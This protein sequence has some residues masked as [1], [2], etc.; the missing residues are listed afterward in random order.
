MTR[1]RNVA[2]MAETA[3]EANENED[4]FMNTELGGKIQSMIQIGITL[5]QFVFGALSLLE[6]SS[7]I[8]DTGASNHMCCDSKHLKTLKPIK[9]IILAYL[10]NGTIKLVYHVGDL[11]LNSTVKL[12]YTLHISIF[13]YNLISVNKLSE[14]ALIRFLFYPSFCLLQD[15]QTMGKVVS[16]LYILDSTFFKPGLLSHYT[17][18]IKYQ[19]TPTKSLPFDSHFDSSPV[20]ALIYSLLSFFHY[21]DVAPELLSLLPG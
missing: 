7:W 15:L 19:H 21:Y 14:I 10:P 13:K 11:H 5:S 9:E 16:R 2:N 18:F 12:T 4:S 3:A 20:P 8:V 17:N 1:G 6:G